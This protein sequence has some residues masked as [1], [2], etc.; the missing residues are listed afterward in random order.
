MSHYQCKSDFLLRYV[1]PSE[2]LY[3]EARQTNQA[4]FDRVE[5]AGGRAAIR[6]GVPNNSSKLIIQQPPRST[7]A[8]APPS[9]P[10]PAM[11][12]IDASAFVAGP[13]PAVAGPPQGTA[14][15]LGDLGA[16]P[17]GAAVTAS[18]AAST[19]S[20]FSA[21]FSA[22]F[23]ATPVAPSP[24]TG[25]VAAAPQPAPLVP[26]S[27][28]PGPHPGPPAPGPQSASDKYAALAELDGLFGTAPASA[29]SSGSVFGA[30]Q[31]TAVNWSGTGFGGWSGAST[32][33]GMAWGDASS[34][35][36]SVFGGGSG[37]GPGGAGGGSVN[38][39]QAAAAPLGVHQQ[40]GAAAVS[41]WSNG[42]PFGGGAPNKPSANP[43][44]GNPF[45]GGAP[46]PPQWGAMPPGPTHPS[47]P[48]PPAHQN[49]WGMMPQASQ[50]SH[51]PFLVS[52]L[53]DLVDGMYVR[54]WFFVTAGCPHSN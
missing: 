13:A 36:T 33:S 37:G 28:Q 9:V 12:K 49:G 44:M 1:A 18:A 31:P 24:W 39:V 29:A 16:D 43:F 14:N 42:N 34:A 48:G 35:G 17:F 8:A 38:G 25:P 51:N 22:A 53:P 30:P 5:K 2:E 54:N 40:G 27:N 47:P 6:S 45:S 26:S 7:A 46:Q 15:L 4:Q 19:S 23:S 11:Q 10:K 3:T 20:A 50:P 32:S 41:S 21:D 52:Y